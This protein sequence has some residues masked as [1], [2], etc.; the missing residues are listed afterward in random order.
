MANE[1]IKTWLTNRAT[2]A[3]A[4][5]DAR[6]AKW[7]VVADGLPAGIPTT[8]PHIYEFEGAFVLSWPKVTGWQT[9]LN[10]IGNLPDGELLEGDAAAVTI[11]A[12]RITVSFGD[13]L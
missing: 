12:I 13:L 4:E 3:K 8:V 9:F 11:G 6:L 7:L 2:A 10:R 1:A 5:I